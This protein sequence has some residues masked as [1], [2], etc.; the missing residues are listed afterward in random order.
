MK[1]L[2]RSILPFSGLVLA[3]ILIKTISVS[4]YTANNPTTIDANLN[5]RAIAASSPTTPEGAI[6]V[7]T[8]EDELNNDGDCSL[9]EAI[10]AANTNTSVDAC[11]TGDVLTDTIAFDVIGTITVTNQLSVTNGGPLIID[12][13]E[14]I[15]TSGSGMTRVWWVEAGSDLILQN[16]AV[17]DGYVGN[18]NGAGLYNNGGNLTIDQCDF[19]GNH[20]TIS[21]S[22]H[23]YGGGIYSV[24]GTLMLLT[25]ASR[26]TDRWINIAMVVESQI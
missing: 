20:F 18:D 1:R 21:D 14:V 25:A 11:G 7:T 24:G 26:T 19:V 17:I 3:I 2:L 9:R 6:L 16:L 12:G 8:L 15:T 22:L 10:Q 23:Y 4:A 13:A 5:N